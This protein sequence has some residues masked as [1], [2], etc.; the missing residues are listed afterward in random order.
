MNNKD[1]QPSQTDPFTYIEST[2]KTNITQFSTQITSEIVSLYNETKLLKDKHTDIT[3]QLIEHKIR[4]DKVDHLSSLLAQTNEQLAIINIRISNLNKDLSKAQMKYDK[5]FL[6]NLTVPGYIGEYS[7]YK[8]LREYIEDNINQ[9]N[10]LIKDKDKNEHEL[11]AYRDKIEQLT[12]QCTQ[13]MT[14]FTKTYMS[15]NNTI[16]NECNAYVDTKYEH[17]MDMIHNLKIANGSEGLKIRQKA[18]ELKKE[19][20]DLKG[21]RE[22]IEGS[23]INEMKECNNKIVLIEK[24]IEECKGEIGEI[25]RKGVNGKYGGNNSNSPMRR[26]IFSSSISTRGEKDKKREMSPIVRGGRSYQRSVEFEKP[27]LNISKGNC[28]NVKCNSVL[29]NSKDELSDSFG[30]MKSKGITIIKEENKVLN[31]SNINSL[32][33]IKDTSFKDKQL[34]LTTCKQQLISN[35]QH[36]TRQTSP[37]CI[38]TTNIQHDTTMSPLFQTTSKLLNKQRSIIFQR[39]RQ[40]NSTQQTTPSIATTIDKATFITYP[41]SSLPFSHS[42]TNSYKNIRSITTSKQKV[43]EHISTKHKIINLQFTGKDASNIVNPSFYDY[44]N[45]NTLNTTRPFSTNT[46][47]KQQSF[48][49][50]IESNININTHK[51]Q[52]HKQ[53]SQGIKTQIDCVSSNKIKSHKQKNKYINTI[54]THSNIQKGNH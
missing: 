24:Q 43:I 29:T 11:K 20:G 3:S 17:V 4:L 31:I 19:I 6:D 32:P 8:T 35:T 21:L 25:K 47:R 13:S 37:Q 27:M 41:H 36:Q 38:T 26:V 2:I 7:Q 45:N 5:I 46:H 10:K 9:V 52:L 54:H 15:Y 40:P 33:D 49:E 34:S 14:N 28:M 50:F 53:K 12:N 30:I 42:S 18:D 22:M 39:E 23:V 1:L 51:H 48:K 16:K 44:S